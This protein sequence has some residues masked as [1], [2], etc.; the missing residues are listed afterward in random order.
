MDGLNSARIRPK[1]WWEK[2]FR[3][4]SLFIRWEIVENLHILCGAGVRDFI[5]VYLKGYYILIGMIFD[6]YSHNPL[7]PTP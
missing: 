1:W 6:K 7:T 4:H 2:S 5:C 3:I